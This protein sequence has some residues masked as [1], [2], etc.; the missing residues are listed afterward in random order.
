[1]GLLPPAAALP[2]AASGGRSLR[3][4]K[5]SPSVRPS[6][7]ATTAADLP[8]ESQLPTA[9]R[10]K[11]GSNLRRVLGGDSLMGF[12][13]L[14]SPFLTVREIEATSEATSVASPKPI[15]PSESLSLQEAHLQADKSAPRYLHRSAR[16]NQRFLAG[17]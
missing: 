12:M 11:V 5:S 2:P 16:L 8:L 4:A 6:S 17:I 7:L 14:D 1:M 9:S 15:L 13:V 10:L 3:Q